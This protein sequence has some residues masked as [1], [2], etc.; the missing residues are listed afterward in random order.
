MSKDTPQPYDANTDIQC[1]PQE[2][3][4]EREIK[5]ACVAYEREPNNE[6]EKMR[7]LHAL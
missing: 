5:L 4:K 3:T 1:D 7:E 2:K 6:K